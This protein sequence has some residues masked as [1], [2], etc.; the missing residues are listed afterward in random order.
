[1]GKGY[2]PVVKDTPGADK[3]P[4][5]ADLFDITKFGGWDKVNTDFFDP[6]QGIVAKIFQDQGKSTASG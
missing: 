2:R 6:E 3:F 1:V 4:E 5:P